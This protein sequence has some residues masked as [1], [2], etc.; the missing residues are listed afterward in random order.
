M[1]RFE[2]YI[3]EQTPYDGSHIGKTSSLKHI[4]MVYGNTYKIEQEG[5]AFCVQAKVGDQW[6]PVTTPM[7]KEGATKFMAWLNSAENDQTS[8]VDTIEGGKRLRDNK[9]GIEDKADTSKIQY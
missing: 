4:K 9:D 7:P 8:M 3:I 5:D 1:S 2:K 6:V